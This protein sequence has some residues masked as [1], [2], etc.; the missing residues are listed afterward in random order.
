LEGGVIHKRLLNW[1]K[2]A[3]FFICQPFDSGDFAAMALDGKGH[4]GQNRSSIHDDRAGPAGS[5]VATYFGAG[6]TQG[7]SEGLGKR[8]T[9][10]YLVRLIPDTQ[11]MG[12]PV[13][14]QGDGSPFFLTGF[15]H[16]ILLLV[17]DLKKLKS[18]LF[19]N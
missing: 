10:G 19:S 5:L 3:A 6:D 8:V 4:A 9:R 13:Y 17:N 14:H 18:H 1:V 16:D 7:F 15:F 12:G 2:L 11:L